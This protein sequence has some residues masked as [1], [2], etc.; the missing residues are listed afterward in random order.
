M[1]AAIKHN[2][3]FGHFAMKVHPI[4]AISE[5]RTKIPEALRTV[6]PKSYKG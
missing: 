5:K 1:E 6:H 2:R 4:L 3:K